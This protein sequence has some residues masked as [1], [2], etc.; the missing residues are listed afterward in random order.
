M[1]D[2]KISNIIIWGLI[3]LIVIVLLMIFDVIPNPSSNRPNKISFTENIVH[4]H[5]NDVK[6]EK[7][8]FATIYLRS[9]PIGNTIYCIDTYSIRRYNTFASIN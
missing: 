9:L 5:I 7:V 6:Q 1:G 2:K 3:A 4:M 8:S